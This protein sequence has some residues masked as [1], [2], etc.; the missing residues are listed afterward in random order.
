MWGYS[1]NYKT[2]SARYIYD[3]DYQVGRRIAATKAENIITKK[4]DAAAANHISSKITALP[5]PCVLQQDFLTHKQAGKFNIV[6]GK[7]GN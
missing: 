5:Y 3:Y 6:I 4:K 2:E 7:G 1:V